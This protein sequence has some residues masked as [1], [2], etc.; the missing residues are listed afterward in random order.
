[1]HYNLPAPARLPSSFLH[2]ARTFEP[3][4]LSSLETYDAKTSRIL[5]HAFSASGVDNSA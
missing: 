3:F 1:M 4:K 2:P 5:T